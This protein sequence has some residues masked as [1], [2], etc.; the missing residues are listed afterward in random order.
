M[1]IDRLHLQD[2]GQFHDKDVTLAPGINVIYGANE[3][4]K[5]TIKDFI[6]DMLYGVDQ[7][8]AGGMRLDH[9][10]K[11]K[12][13]QGD[14]YSGTMEV[15]TEDKD[16][17]IERNFARQE[18]KTVLTDLDTGKE[19]ALNEPDNLLGTVIDTDKT[20]YLNTLC[21][22]QMSA[23]TGKDIADRLNSYIISVAS[24]KAGDVDPVSAIAEL[25][26]KKESFSDE[27]ME[28]KEKELSAKLQLERDFD[29]ELTAV[30]EER[31]KLEASMKE[32]NKEQLQFTP[33][34]PNRP[35]EEEK[36]EP[37]Q[38][39]D[40][41]HLSKRERDLRML[42]G[43]GKKSI[44]D[45]VMVILLMGLLLVALFIG[46]A[47]AVPVNS[48]QIKMGII[49]I[50]VFFSLLTVGQILVRRSKLY[51]MLEEIEI[52][53]SFEE[54]K[55]ESVG[56][57]EQKEFNDRMAELKKKE[58]E[59]VKDR[60]D[61]EQVL[62]ELTR[63]KEQRG[64][65]Q[66]EILALDLAIKTIQDLSEEIYDS[67]GSVLNDQV[68]AIISRITGKKY[69][70][71]KIDDQLHVRVRSGSSY[72]SME[73]LSSGTMEQ[74]YLALRLAIASVL[75]KEELP[76]IMDDIFVTYD[77]QRIYDTLSCLGVYR[78]RQI[79]IF[80]T[81]QEIQGMFTRLGIQSKYIAI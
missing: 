79:I 16:Y 62:S 78:N 15:S 21:I 50:G 49:A 75:I 40:T 46:I 7:V 54:A 66:K 68:S 72:I 41:K 59:I 63:L 18:R 43:M 27:A 47:Y 31:A 19:V 44:L 81:N 10:E 53:Q 17:R 3:A 80:T 56:A 14:S 9:Y 52:E 67:F 57:S 73:Y 12:P 37:M 24:S 51:K 35:E 64:T 6:V 65:N 30:R 26:K 5:S 76:I 1:R 70:E 29:A 4:G 38:A 69:S 60:K 36:A 74:I 48:P 8:Y 32:D 13:I 45:N 58:E 39:A 34:R 22:G 33:I 23:A 77:Y 42:R 61:Q 25:K 71:V 28:A 55:T 11:R 2:Y 20:T